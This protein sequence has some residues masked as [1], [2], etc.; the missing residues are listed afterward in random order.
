M[1]TLRILALLACCLAGSAC[2]VSSPPITPLG[3]Q[4]TDSIKNVTDL[5]V[6]SE[7]VKVASRRIIV[8]G[9]FESLITQPIGGLYDYDDSEVSPLYRTYYF[10][11]GDLELFEHT[12]DY[13]RG[14]GLDLRRDY[15]TTGNPSLVETPLR[16]QNPLIVRT[17][18][19]LLQHD[20]VRSGEP[21]QDYEIAHLTV[22]I[23]VFDTQG[24]QRYQSRQEILGR[25]PH[26]EDANL[27][28]ILGLT[29]G[30]R[31]LSDPSFLNA[32]EA[33]AGAS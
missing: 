29:L 33:K 31:L 14:S 13:L 8:L 22:E 4:E 20:Q 19:L 23:S 28:R 27:L 25:L 2:W 24:Q 5:V 16:Q 7:P 15:G 21:P 12:S 18:I 3:H 10:K 17:K 11:H 30:Q 6:N 9:R 26:Q 32:I 1:R